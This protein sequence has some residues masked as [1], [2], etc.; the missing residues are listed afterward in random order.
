MSQV[1]ASTCA[2]CFHSKDNH[3]GVCNGSLTCMCTKY[4]APF[5]YEFAHRVEQERHIR[6]D[7]YSRCEYILREI[8][9]SRNAGE[10]SFAKIYY[11]IWEGLKIRLIDPQALD[12]KTWNRLSNQD[13]INREKRRVKADHPDLATYKKEVLWHQTAI[14]QA[15]LEMSVE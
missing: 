1:V 6:K 13:T 5:M 4:V 10:K 7:I 8:P 3:Q 15:L 9:P 11:E 2:K 12:T 14:F